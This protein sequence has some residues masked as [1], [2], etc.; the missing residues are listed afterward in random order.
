MSPDLVSVVVR[1][2][3]FSCLFQAAGAA[4]FMQLF[5]TGVLRCAAGIVRLG[6][7]CARGERAAGGSSGA[8]G[9]AYGR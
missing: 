7:G 4:F 8:R 6:V 5:G 3:A 2:L 9:R 1:A